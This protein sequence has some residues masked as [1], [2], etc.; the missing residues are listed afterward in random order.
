MVKTLCILSALAT[1]VAIADTADQVITFGSSA[2]E[3]STWNIS[4]GAG[5]SSLIAEQDGTTLT[6]TQNGS[7]NLFFNTTATPH[8]TAPD[9]LDEWTA[10]TGFS[11]GQSLVGIAA[12]AGDNRGISFDL[13]GASFAAGNQVTLYVTVA[14][15]GAMSRIDATVTGLDGTITVAKTSGSD[16]WESPVDATD[17]KS[18][19]A[20]GNNTYT[21]FKIEGTLTGE[22]FGV[23]ITTN[24]AK[25]AITSIA[26]SV[27]PEPTTATLS[28]LA[29]AGLCARRRR[30]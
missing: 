26:Y 2:P 16:P 21:I 27:T 19:W 11:S 1:S 10:Y 7:A 15:S 13:T 18:I 30:K 12:G 4:S 22:T 24:N 9:A 28:L 23:D 3:A 20:V 8:T 29:L 17:T 6:I 14:P 25:P 5:A